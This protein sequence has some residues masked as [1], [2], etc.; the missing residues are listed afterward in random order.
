MDVNEQLNNLPEPDPA[1]LDRVW[2]RYQQTRQA[3]PSRVGWGWT[4]GLAGAVAVAAATLLVLRADDAPRRQLLASAEQTTRSWSD[5]IGL[6]LQ[7][8][9]EIAGTS[10]DA[11]IHWRTGTVTASVTPKSGNKLAV[12]TEEARVEVVGTVFSVTRDELGVTTWVDRGR[13]KV[14]CK[15]GWEGEIG[16]EDGKKVCLPVRPALL[17]GR[18]DALAASSA[19]TALQLETLDRGLALAE[20]GSATAG[21]LLRR[22]VDVQ[23]A[24]G[25]VEGAVK[26]AEAYLSAGGPYAVE[27]RRAVV[28]AA[29]QDAHGCSTALP[30]LADLEHT[31]DATDRVLLARCVAPEQPSRARALLEDARPHLDAAWGAQADAVEALL[32]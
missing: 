13:V 26:D 7:G 27:V 24:Q 3:R 12:V 4:L 22:R 25:A 30:F 17:V 5:D 29:L 32:R 31:G 18:A 14:A 23:V 19:S 15:D 21:E 20:Q 10:K 16:P 28:Y 8:R 11:E 6:T 2:R 9:G 1:S